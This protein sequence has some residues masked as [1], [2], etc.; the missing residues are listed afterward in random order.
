MKNL[1]LIAEE[2]FNK[3]RGRFPSIT[4]G[5]QEGKVTNQP[6]QAR[7][8]DFDYVEGETKLGK[9]SI[10]LTDETVEV[11]YSSDFVANEDIITKENWYGFLKELRAFS[12]K[13][14]LGFDT[15]NINKSNLDQRDYQFLATNRSG[16]EKMNE[17]KMYGTSTSSYQKIGEAR[18]AIKHSKPIN[19]ESAT[20]RIRS[21]KAIYIESGDGERFKYPLKHLNGAR[22]MARHVAEGGNPYDDF[23]K[24]ITGLSEELSSLKK[25]KSYVNRSS[26]MAEGLSGYIDPVNER[27]ANIKKTISSLQN[28]S[29][30]KSAFE[31]YQIPIVE[32]VPEDVAEN[33]ID[34]LTIKQFNEELKDVFP[35]VYRLVSEATKAKTITA[36]SLLAEQQE[37]YTVQSGDTLYSIAKQMV[38]Y[39]MKGMDIN[40]AVAE[41]ADMNGIE[42]PA[43]IQPGM[44]LQIPFVI[45][46][47]G[48]DPMTGE[49]IT[50]GLGPSA[51]ESQLEDSFEEMMGQFAE[52]KDCDECGCSPCECDTTEGNKF[53]YDVRMAKMNGKKKGDEIDG[54][55][56]KKI[57]LEKD[58][59]IPVTEFVL[60]LFDRDQGT[61]PKGETAVLTAIEKDYGEQFIEPA[62]QFIERVQSTYEQY[63]QP[64]LEPMIDEEPGTVMEP[65]VSQEETDIKRLAGL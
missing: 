39:E 30:Y 21:I 20:G 54:P 56:G 37:T 6:T 50:R 33:W 44:E 52:G 29:T 53:G 22:A 10:S 58:E 34:Q 59:K 55:D 57:K 1:D 25:F 27:L 51:Y 62:K 35:F 60:S 13:R 42:D 12:K 4:I 36:E 7:F 2:L 61:F 14:M 65:T 45:G 64:V 8:Y 5:D 47:V 43:M 18:I 32:D 16:D 41:I 63:T 24:H 23:G 11:M 3:V 28:E 48:G 9:V 40:D 49:P 38:K 19:T 31:G 15:R 46:A 17:S 26:V